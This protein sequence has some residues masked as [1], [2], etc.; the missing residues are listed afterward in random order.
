M[1]GVFLHAAGEGLA[2]YYKKLGFEDFFYRNHFSYYRDRASSKIYENQNVIHFLSPEEYY[3]KRLK[4]LENCC[5][6]NWA[7]SF[8]NFINNA[9]VRFCEYSNSIFSYRQ[10]INQTIV[11]E[12]LGNATPEE[13]AQLLFNRFPEFKTVHFRLPGND[14]CCGQIKWC[15]PP[16]DTLNGGYFSFAME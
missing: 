13:V 12:L 16:R 4:K 11:D 1:A 8:F 9:G 15:K 3:Q 7:K 2:N 10:E 6:I 14:I 5:F